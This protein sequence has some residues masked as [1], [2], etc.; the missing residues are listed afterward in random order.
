MADA[1][2][3]LDPDAPA[4]SIRQMAAR[5]QCDPSTVTFLADRLMT[6]AMT[7][8]ARQRPDRSER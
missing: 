5:L 2:W 6:K 8:E 4:P 3:Q 1:L 7:P